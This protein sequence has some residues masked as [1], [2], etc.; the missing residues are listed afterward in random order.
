M[1]INVLGLFDG[2]SC[3]QVALERAK[4]KINNYYASEIDKYAIQITQKNYPNTIQLGDINNWKNWNIDW[5]NIDLLIG[6][7]PC[8]G[9]SFAGKQLNFDDERSKLFFVYVDI[10]NHIKKL[11]PNVKFLL[12]NVKMKD[13]YRN[14]ISELLGVK[15]I[16]INS[17]LLSAQNRIRLYWCNWG[18]PSQNLFGSCYLPIPQPRDKKIFL[19]DIVRNIEEIDPKYFLRKE[20]LLKLDFTGLSKKTSSKVQVIANG[21]KYRKSY[22][23]FDIN[24][25][26]ETLDTSQGGGRGLY[27]LIKI[28][29]T[30]KIKE[31]QNKACCLTAGANSGGNHSDMDILLVQINRGFNQGRVIVKKS[32]TLTTGQ[33][34]Y[35]NI[36]FIKIDDDLYV[37]IRLPPIECERLQTLPDDYTKG[38]SDTQRYKSL[39]NGWTVDVIA[40][41]L[42]G[43]GE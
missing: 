32:S 18:Q 5:A 7:S 1:G 11:N 19:K 43:M 36:A 41:I 12:E 6:G 21:E 10:L 38:V 27:A 28:D 20:Q 4:I 23:V 3:G 30:G 22:R 17:S 24:G 8:Q 31:N 14:I 26:S 16:K 9:F 42:G 34:A 40:H 33:W 35:N 37:A 2:I 39:G 29:K 15:P 13:E 25:K